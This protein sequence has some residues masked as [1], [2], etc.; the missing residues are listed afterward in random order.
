[1][2]A[3]DIDVRIG[4]TTTPESIRR[5]QSDINNALRTLS[6]ELNISTSSLDD[7]IQRGINIDANIQKAGLAPNAGRQL[8]ESIENSLAIKIDKISATARS[9]A[10]LVKELEDAV[11]DL[12][13]QV[14]P[15]AQGGRQRT[16]AFNS[17]SDITPSEVG[18]G[19]ASIQKARE[20]VEEA[21]LAL[22]EATER[23]QRALAKDTAERTA[24]QNKLLASQLE[25]IREVEEHKNFVK[26]QQSALDKAVHAEIRAKIELAE[27]NKEQARRI[28]AQ[29]NKDQNTNLQN[30][31]KQLQKLADE[32]ARQN[33]TVSKGVRLQEDLN[34]VIADRIR[35]AQKQ[36]KLPTKEN[37]IAGANTGAA[38]PAV[39]GLKDINAFAQKLDTR[40]LEVL[41]RLLGQNAIA[42]AKAAGVQ[43]T[44]GGAVKK[45]DLLI[46]KYNLS[47]TSGQRAAFEFGVS[48]TNAAQRL[49]AW[50]TPATFIFSALG[51][52]RSA[53]NEIIALD[54]EARRLTFFDPKTTEDIVSGALKFGDAARISQQNMEL[55]IKT[56]KRAGL[57]IKDVTEAFTVSARTGQP[58]V[59]VV[60]SA[61]EASERVASKFVNTVNQLV[62]FEAGAL[63]AEEAA[64]GLNAILNQFQ[65]ND[66]R[67]KSLGVVENVGAVIASVADE[68]AF[69][70]SQLID[71]TSRLGAAFSNLQNVNFVATI[72][73]IGA[74]SDATG[75]SAERLGT[76]F[77]Q[78][79]TLAIQN[80]DKIKEL[81]GIEIIG[82]DGLVD[83]K[84]SLQVL[85]EI[86]KLNPTA[87][88]QLARLVF[89][90]RNLAD[91]QALSA[92]I[93]TLEKKFGDVESEAAEVAFVM[94]SVKR[95]FLKEKFEAQGLEA[96]INKLSVSFTALVESAGVQ[97]FLKT[98]I[99]LSSS[100]VTGFNSLVDVL[101]KFGPAIAALGIAKIGP[102]LTA[103]LRGAVLGLTSQLGNT[104]GR[105]AVS[106]LL[107]SQKTVIDG[108]KRAQ[109]EGFI[110]QEK[111][112]LLQKEQAAL[113]TK[114]LQS[115]QAIL[116][117]QKQ[118]VASRT[119]SSG[120]AKAENVAVKA[121]V[122]EQQKL[123]TLIKQQEQLRNKTLSDI[124][125]T[126]FISKIAQVGVLAGVLAGSFFAN[127][128]RDSFAKGGA[129][130][131]AMAEGF[132]GAVEG[133]LLGAFTGS[134]LLPGIGTVIGAVGGAF[135]HGTQSF[136]SSLEQSQQELENSLQAQAK[137]NEAADIQRE[138]QAARRSR[139]DSAAE[140]RTEEQQ[141]LIRLTREYEDISAAIERNTLNEAYEKELLVKQ[142]AKLVEIEKFKEELGKK[143]AKSERDRAAAAR[144]IA[145]IRRDEINLLS[146][147]ERFEATLDTVL[148]KDRALNISVTL[149][150]TVFEAQL[151]NIL[152]ELEVTKGL[153]VKLFN[154]GAEAAE[155]EK[156]DKEIHDLEQKAH[157][158]RLDNEKEVLRLRKEILDNATSDTSNQINA[159]ESASHAVASSFSDAADSQ[160]ELASL[161][162]AQA[163]AA[164]QVIA[165][166]A[167]D[168]ASL[169][170]ARGASVETRILSGRREA[171]RQITEINRIAARSLG[172]ARSGGAESFKN[173]NEL[174][175]A[176]DRLVSV[177]TEATIRGNEKVFEEEKKVFNFELAQLNQR[178]ADEK[179][180]FALRVQS[181][182]S[183]LEVRKDVLNQEVTI[184]NERISAER[185][186]QNLRIDQQREFGRIILEGPEQFLA[187]A[188]DIKN[189]RSF[190]KGISEINA[191][192][193]RQISGRSQNARQSGQ[194]SGLQSV[195]KGLEQLQ[196]I[197]GSDV[198]RGISNAELQKVFERIQV[199][200]P[201]EI[202]KD[203]ERQRQELE[204]ATDLQKQLRARQE[205]LALLAE[206]ENALASAQLR[207]NQEATNAAINQRDALISIVGESVG[208]QRKQLVAL[209]ELQQG[210]SL[211]TL[212]EMTKRIEDFADIGINFDTGKLEFT[213]KNGGE[214]TA[215]QQA[216]IDAAEEVANKTNEA[217]ERL[218]QEQARL[219]TSTMKLS[220]VYSKVAVVVDRFNTTFNETVGI[221]TSANEKLGSS[222]NGDLTTQQVAAG[223]SPFSGIGA[224]ADAIKRIEDSL[225][226]LANGSGFRIEDKRIADLERAIKESG[227]T[228][229]QRDELARLRKNSFD[230]ANI[231]GSD[232]NAAS[233]AA[234]RFLESDEISSGLESGFRELLGSDSAFLKSIKELRGTGVRGERNIDPSRLREVLSQAGLSGV[235]RDI[236]TKGEA[237]QLA[238]R[239]LKFANE[240]NKAPDRLTEQ[241]TRIMRDLLAT[242]IREGFAQVGQV[243]LAKN[244]PA[245]AAEQA[246][247]AQADG[248]LGLFTEGNAIEFA[249][250]FSKASS[251]EFEATWTE[252]SQRVGDAVVSRMVQNLENEV[253]KLQTINI[254]VPKLDINLTGFIENRING[255]DFLTE[256]N[257]TLS[258]NG[259][260]SEQVKRIR[261]HVAKLL[262]VMVRSGQLN[263]DVRE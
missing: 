80:A 164:S 205:R 67:F 51:A 34:K 161:I 178:A 92:A 243:M 215:S 244:R 109:D 262:D 201:D 138:V 44:F 142:G 76:A 24:A 129:N 140:K 1:M 40:Q 153:K 114:K 63:G 62:R 229:Q 29:Q 163:D 196:K 65:I 25:Q 17:A 159:W 258:E 127:G 190:F 112:I 13:V 177:M 119:L 15:N 95:A 223:G 208:V 206:T 116:G 22:A 72:G 7:F 191:D 134:A 41:N 237:A 57:S 213:P 242:E 31:N 216:L 94:D 252:M 259:L 55:I 170:E 255:E 260:S 232:R 33:G 54:R 81:T 98:I 9:R 227:G 137:A 68:S 143:A 49:L 245:T 246:A 131:K 117:L 18:S 231:S 176:A 122:A 202:F 28:I 71:A 221:L 19:A 257:E 20:R 78:M 128:I 26:S 218:G 21:L 126:G 52:L 90:R 38:L 124:K 45:A 146:S 103:G 204:N 135:L 115:E 179:A 36:G 148:S 133:A 167:A 118:V 158:L 207:I 188:N 123:N 226:P 120:A 53:T 141:K 203:L 48:A 77:R 233:G 157:K 241:A 69:N 185:E 238:D 46:Q 14:G 156:I 149:K 89:D 42:T 96:S 82:K 23:D 169:L 151:A 209:L 150:K 110:S 168:I 235:A 64:T 32:L 106:S 132:A 144:E 50:A 74:A 121:L 198:I 70:V 102:Q 195:L 16:Q 91:G 222:K 200:A 79:G 155:I 247:G 88:D 56:A 228:K 211:K 12:N 173:G 154:S 100:A 101:S 239:L 59:D 107:G 193:L 261:D 43:D 37:G 256:L 230:T 104:A 147:I 240:L 248:G 194:F 183:E 108:I 66:D 225:R 111:S 99:S 61:G 93:G 192:S 5:I 199:V 85:R 139:E 75:A 3:A 145:S 39:N 83:F 220:D 254:S 172:V 174:K 210:E 73:L 152:Q 175:A 27:A 58:F 8:R 189:A 171:Q 162:F 219:S 97:T 234:R 249:R 251:E 236:D 35:E 11:R 160:R 182:K 84:A 197:G 125:S 10:A 214:F 186:L 212:K 253:N 87:A 184:I 181:T 136:K 187:V 47:L 6:P 250:T 130:E 113:Q 2:P 105:E 263:P 165:G 30:E 86:N 180:L 60:N 217:K 166:R 224:G 4:L